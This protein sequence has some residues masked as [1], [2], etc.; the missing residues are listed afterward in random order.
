MDILYLLR[1]IN[2]D[3]LSSAK[4]TISEIIE[5]IET[6]GLEGT[7]VFIRGKK[8]YDAQNICNEDYIPSNDKF[9]NGI[10]GLY[11]IIRVPQNPTNIHNKDL[12]EELKALYILLIQEDNDSA[13]ILLN[14]IINKLCKITWEVCIRIRGPSGI[15]RSPRCSKKS[16]EQLLEVERQITKRY[17]EYVNK[18][19][20][21]VQSSFDVSRETLM[22][23]VGSKG[24]KSKCELGMC[25][26]E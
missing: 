19:I 8:G 2:R 11:D 9:Y 20:T 16:E 4:P 12:I 10:Y 22:N 25:D 14:E 6:K 21:F 15:E 7:F 1:K 18:Y 5:E 23:F 3:N 13:L 17:E 24:N 26:S